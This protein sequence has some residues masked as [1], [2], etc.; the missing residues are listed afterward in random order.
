MSFTSETRT[1]TSAEVVKSASATSTKNE[2]DRWP[3]T[4]LTESALSAIAAVSW[5]ESVPS[6]RKEKKLASVPRK[7]KVNVWPTLG[8]TARRGVPTSRLA[9]SSSSARENRKLDWVKNG[10]SFGSSVVLPPVHV[11][12]VDSHEWLAVTVALY[13]PAGRLQ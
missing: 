7:E 9:R 6:A 5:I 12:P 11:A 3:A 1:V 10:G 2:N 8:S 13:L 4:P